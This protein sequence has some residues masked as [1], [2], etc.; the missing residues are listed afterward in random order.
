MSVEPRRGCGYRK[1]GGLYLVSDGP[2]AWCHRLPLPL[3]VCPCCGA[4]VKPTRG[5]TWITPATLFDGPCGTIH[6]AYVVG[7]D[8]PGSVTRALQHCHECPACDPTGTRAGLLWVGGSFYATPDAF[9]REANTLGISRRIHA[10]PKGLVLGQTWVYLAHREAL[11]IDAPGADLMLTGDDTPP[12]NRAGIF[13]AF[14]PM[15]VEQLIRER[16][17]TTE[18]TTAL[19]KRG[20]TPVVV[21]DDDPDHAGPDEDTDE[22]EATDDTGRYPFTCVNCQ[23]IIYRG[24][25]PYPE[26]VCLKCVSTYRGRDEGVAETAARLVREVALMARV[27]AEMAPAPNET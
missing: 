25:H 6:A 3:A 17:A 11:P 1:V 9:L 22:G 12:P 4:G 16:D 2:I 14:R 13:S 26:A 18:T 24:R 10:V 27:A 5:W 7:H 23:S 19:A 20:I 21:P 8:D 15:R